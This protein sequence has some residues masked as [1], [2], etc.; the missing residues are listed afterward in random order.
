MQ[1]QKSIEWHY[2]SGWT[3][4]ICIEVQRPEEG[5]AREYER[6]WKWFRQFGVRWGVYRS[7][8]IICQDNIHELF[9]MYFQVV[10]RVQAVYSC[11]E[12]LYAAYKFIA[13]L[14]VTQCTCEIMFFETEAVANKAEDFT[15]PEYFGVTYANC[16][17][18]RHG[19]ENQIK[20][21]Q[22]YW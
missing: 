19:N 12:N 8:W 4:F 22:N 13:T 7:C 6:Q 1:C 15:H 11:Y 18:K 9:V 5:P 10:T 2:R 20:Q 3:Y 17:W 21:R 16:Y 14:S